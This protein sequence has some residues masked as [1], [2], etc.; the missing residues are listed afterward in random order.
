MP[1]LVF[2]LSVVRQKDAKAE[3]LLQ[4]CA[5]DSI[6]VGLTW[7]FFLSLNVKQLNPLLKTHD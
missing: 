1:K 2:L 5:T 6:T 4:P 3:L 7:T